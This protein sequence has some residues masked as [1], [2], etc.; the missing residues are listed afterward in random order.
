MKKDNSRENL[1][2]IRH[3]ALNL[4]KAYTKDKLSMKA[5]RFRCFLTTISYVLSF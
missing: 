5:K 4:Y 2:V 3:I 1:A